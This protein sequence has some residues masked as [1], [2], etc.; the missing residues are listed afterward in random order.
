LP[1]VGALRA[2][3]EP[4]AAVKD[5]AR[6]MIRAAYGLETPPTGEAARLDLRVH[7]RVVRLVAEL[8]GW[9]ELGGELGHDEL[10]GLLDGAAVRLA[11]GAGEAG[12]VAV[13]DLL[14]ARTRPFEV[15][16]VLGLEGGR[17]PRRV[18]GS[19]FLDGERKA[20]PG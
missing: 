14:R 16:F 1:R 7:E 20:E 17:P 10:V 9:L 3:E 18:Q 15:V 13:L 2:A 12:R 4:L 19:P 11:G 6:A 5:L 8:E